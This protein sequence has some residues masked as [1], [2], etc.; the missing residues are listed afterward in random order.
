MADPTRPAHRSPAP[1]AAS[2]HRLLD[3]LAA[4]APAEELAAEPAR[5]RADG[6]DAGTVEQV[7]EA[8]EVALAVRRALDQHL[9]R[10]A[11]LS[12]LFDTAGDLAG[13]RDLDAVLRAIV[14]RARALLGADVAYLTLNDPAAHDTFM[15]VT[16]GSVSAA[17]QQLRLGMG[18]G[19]GGLVAQTARPY[20]STDYRTDQRFLHTGAIDGGVAEEGLRGI[21]GVPLRLGEEIIGVLFAA[22]RTPR[23][24]TP[25]A[26][27]LLGSLAAHAAVAIDSARLLEETRSTLVRLEAA[28]E[29]ARAHS[30]ALHRASDAH[31]RLTKLV[32]RGAGIDDVAAEIA[33]LLGGGLSVHD[34]DGSEL[35]RAHTDPVTPSTAGLAASHTDGRAAFADGVWTCAVL[36]GTEPLGSIVLT[37]RTELT[38]PDR[39]LFERA[40]LVTALLLLLRRSVAEA[41]DR[42]RGELLDDLLAGPDSSP[43]WDSGSL[44][45][46][47][48]RLGVHLGRPHI[49][50]VL[51][52]EPQLRSR[53]AAE[54]ARTARGLGGL[55]GT[56]HG[57]VVLLAPGDRP[58]DLAHTLA[59]DLG[60]ALAA[61]VTVGAAGPGAG[62]DEL[63]ASHAEA[64]R[65][66]QALHAL[67]RTGEGADIADLGFV[68]ILLGGDRSDVS[69]YVQR[70]LG[71]VLAYDAERGT[72]LMRTLHAYYDHG[73]SLA[74]AKDA[75]HVHVN[76]VVQRLDRVAQLL[77]PD[78]N[79]PAHALE[80][81]LA[82][83]LDRLTRGTDGSP[84]GPGADAL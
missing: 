38:E 75:L 76:T 21:L 56:R 31:D 73:S 79:S 2:V 48:R 16:E 4:G 9:R 77:G 62:P 65:C 10:E 35:A 42:V 63:P 41:E 46:R 26:I 74:R 29:T 83:R 37:G 47:A 25:D 13:L 78:W 49:V 67:G 60:R 33:A 40:A 23:E 11:E 15:R 36:A 57:Q 30:A 22:N 45:L 28:N 58:G 8:T 71:P 17:F 24:F 39:R 69:S 70:I 12:A 68:G 66:L 14:R 59:A 43:H 84:L 3:L 6:A 34:T 54:T 5:T 50:A 82:L 7:A 32:L 1:A 53:L 44:T 80:T 51:G 20:A 72:E 61:P 19:L 27:D 64:V 52:C 55:T 18:E 81:Q